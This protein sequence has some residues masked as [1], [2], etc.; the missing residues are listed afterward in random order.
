MK[1]LKRFKGNL[2]RISLLILYVP[3][4]VLLSCGEFSLELEDDD[5]LFPADLE[6]AI[7]NELESNEYIKLKFSFGEDY[8]IALFNPAEDSLLILAPALHDTVLVWRDVIK[9]RPSGLG[10]TFVI[11]GDYSEV[12]F[13]NSISPGGPGNTR[14]NM[15]IEG[16]SLSTSFEYF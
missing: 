11:W 16:D 5:G 4:F 9:P 8:D 14:L 15:I 1:L 2:L 12:L 6:I 10:Y 3:I 13:G 7:T